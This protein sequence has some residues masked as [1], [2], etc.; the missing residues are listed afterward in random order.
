[1]NIVDKI[2]DFEQG[3]LNEDELIDFF[4]EL[5]NTG[6]V[7]KLQGMYQRTAYALIEAGLCYR[8]NG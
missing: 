3:N 2:M 5:I 7:W 6:I 4:Q 1:M 8:H